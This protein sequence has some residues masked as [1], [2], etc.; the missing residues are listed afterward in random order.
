MT[1]IDDLMP[2]E[3]IEQQA[4]ARLAG[5]RSDRVMRYDD[6]TLGDT[7]DYVVKGVIAAGELGLLYASAKA[8]KSFYAQHLGL[9]IAAGRLHAGRRVRPGLVVHVALESVSAMR[10]RVVAYKASADDEALPWVLL[11]TR[12]DIFDAESRDNLVCD[13]LRIQQEVGQPLR[14]TIFDTVARAMPGRDENSRDLGDALALMHDLVRGYF[15]TSATLAVHHA[16]KDAGRGARGHSSAYGTPDTIIVIEESEGGERVVSIEVSRNGPA[17]EPIASFHLEPVT[18][19]LDADGDPVTAALLH[20]TD[21]PDQRPTA[22]SRLTTKQRL[23]MEAVEHALTRSATFP[24]SALMAALPARELPTGRSVVDEEAVVDE[25]VARGI[26]RGKTEKNQRRGIR[27]L[28]EA[29]QA[30]GKIGRRDGFVWK[31]K[32]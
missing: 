21:T 10:H 7:S 12:L 25:A 19:G 32:G 14:L 8:G 5:L 22:K 29:L 31:T 3:S 4:A 17:G 27:S 2:E 24:P 13:L 15:P 9:D 6:I 23:L 11:D 20:W 1:D 28:L 16:G 18:L 26:S 30:M